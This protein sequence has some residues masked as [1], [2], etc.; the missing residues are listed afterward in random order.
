MERNTRRRMTGRIGLAGLGLAGFALVLAVGTPP[1]SAAQ[2]KTGEV[3]IGTKYVFTS[4]YVKGEIP[5]RVHLP[6]SP[7]KGG[8]PPPVLYLL[9]IADDFPYA[10]ATADFLARCG[11]IPGLIVVGVD[12][13]KLSG[14]PQGLIDFLDKELVPFVEKTAGAGP[15]R[16]LFGHSGRSFAALFILLNRPD[17]FE[18]YICPGLGLTWPLE[19][20]RI[21]FAAL[22]EARLAKLS[23]LPKT[24]VFS[25]GDEEKF[26]PG[27]ERFI[28]VLKAK[29]PSDFRWTYLRMPGEDHGSTKLKTL[30]QGLEFIFGAGTARS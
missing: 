8:T 23:S 17:L 29:A 26:F 24:L 7:G 4:A 21:D 9:E 5:V 11:R 19:P 16:L 12:V 22:A 15:R 2:S 3:S 20:G 18:G 14:P 13:D 28:A 27:I 6:A 30:Y 1:G 10:S 25:L